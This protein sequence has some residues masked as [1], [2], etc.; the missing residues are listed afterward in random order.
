MLVNSPL[1]VRQ[2]NTVDD[3]AMVKLITYYQV[4]FSDELRNEARVGREACLIDERGLCGLNFAS[5]FSNST[6]IS[7]V[8]AIGRTDPEPAP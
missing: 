2:S 8:P 3:A 6:C 1:A 7:I 4:L 5:R